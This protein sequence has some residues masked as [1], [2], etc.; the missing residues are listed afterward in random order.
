MVNY[1]Q[2]QVEAIL[3]VTSRITLRGG[4]RYV[5]GDATVRAGTLDLSGPLASR[6]LKRHVGLAGLTVR[7][8]Q[9]LSLN[10]DYE[11]ASTDQDYFRTSLYNYHK[12]RARARYQAA[13][14]LWFQAN[15]TLLDNQNPSAGIQYDFRSRDNSLAAFWTPNGGKH[16]SVTAEYDR[17]TMYSSINYLLLPFYA[18]S[19]SV[20]RENAH[21]ASSSIDIVLPAVAGV[22]ARLSAG[23]SLFISAGS[24]SSRY[25][26]PLGRLSLPL[27]KHVQWNTEWRWY[28]FG[29]QLYMYEGFRTHIFMTGLRLSK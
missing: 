25:Y 6:Q 18:P 14:S 20:Y 29:E 8:W 1:N 3:D 16:F 4:Y 17:S 26:Q 5:W 21:T 2:Q 15:F 9:K 24:R 23:G 10:V 11:G 28:G 22:A 27:Q 7:P 19:V 13:S 12:V